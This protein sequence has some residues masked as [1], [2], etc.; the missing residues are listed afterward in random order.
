MTIQQLINGSLRDLEVILSGQTPSNDQSN[1]ALNTLNDILGNWSHE[2]LLVPTHTLTSFSV[3]AGQVA[4]TMGVGG[5]WVTPSLPLKIKGA[6]SSLAGFQKGMAV[7]KMEEY[8]ALLSDPIAETAALPVTMGID[9]AAPL[10]NVRLHPTPNSS[11]TLIEVSYWTALASVGLTDNVSFPLPAFQEAVRN[12]LTLRLAPMHHV[13]VSQ[14]LVWNAASSRQA[15]ARID[16]SEVTE[17][18]VQP[19]AAP[20]ALPRAA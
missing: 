19:V 17:N 14:A 16:P 3:I 20:Q 9:N 5:N 15:L 18:P 6:V 11:A 13:P 10:R 12:E 8:Q 2:G 4:Y 1:D 7:V